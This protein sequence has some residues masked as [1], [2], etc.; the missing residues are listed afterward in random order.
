MFNFFKDL[1]SV[2][3]D[4]VQ[5]PNPH[6]DDVDSNSVISDEMS[7]N[8]ILKCV[9]NLKNGKACGDDLIIIEYITNT[10]HILMPLH[11]NFLILYLILV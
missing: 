9:K 10:C 8:E 11:I 1:N 7:G 2:D 3:D 4:K 6:S 5:T